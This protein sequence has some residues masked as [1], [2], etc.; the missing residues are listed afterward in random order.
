MAV[1]QQPSEQCPH[2]Y[3]VHIST[4]CPECQALKSAPSELED[5]S[6][7]VVEERNGEESIG[8]RETIPASTAQTAESRRVPTEVV[9]SAA[10]ALKKELG[11]EARE[12][13]AFESV[14]NIESRL[15]ALDSL[16]ATE[17]KDRKE[18]V[19]NIKNELRPI[20]EE[21]HNL[22]KMIDPTEARHEETYDVLKSH[23]DA[24]LTLKKKADELSSQ[25][26][27]EI[28]YEF[29]DFIDNA[30]VHNYIAYKKS[31]QLEVSAEHASQE[32]YGRTKEEVEKIKAKNRVDVA[33]KIDELAKKPYIDLA[34]IEELHALNNR[35]VVPEDFSQMRSKPGDNI[36]FGQ[37]VGLLPRDVGPE[38][39]GVVDRM[40]ELFDK[41]ALGM[42]KA[43]YEVQAA[44]LHN[45]MLDIHP[46]KDRNGSTS[47]M[48]LEL[49]MTREGYKPPAERDKDYYRSLRKMLNNNVVA[50]GAVGYEQYCIKY[51][52]GY[53]ASE[54]IISDKDRKNFY[55]T[56]IDK[57]KK[58]RKK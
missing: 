10:A 6:T 57:I 23:M 42:S 50:I 22:Y 26:F 12:K 11:I 17:A 44:K 52:P 27:S 2:G 1:E 35:S 20:M 38:M 47:L 3:P 28:F 9:G 33:K 55:E 32:I 24:V 7:E 15:D 13:A 34:D 29:S 51:K 18:Q 53:F 21:I 48:V 46:F 4:E 36:V 19:E 49:M 30:L 25:A 41:K 31:Q 37:R 40:N 14:Q 58:A 5:L 43:Q 54:R 16:I 56:V 39:Q 45:D 8:M